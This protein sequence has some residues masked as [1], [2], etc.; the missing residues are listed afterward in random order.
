[1]AKRKGDFTTTER[2]SEFQETW[3]KNPV[4]GVRDLFGAEP[5][6]Q[7]VEL[8]R[9]A[10]DP[11][12]RVAVSSC[13]GAG[14][15]ATLAWLTYLFLLTQEDC[16]IMMTSP[17]FQQLNRVYKTEC[18]KWRGKMPKPIADLF[19][20]TREQVKLNSDTLVQR[21]D[22]VTLSTDNKESLQGGHAKNYV[23]LIDEASAA[24]PEAFAVLQKTLS[25]DTGGRFILTSNPTRS[26]GPF[27]DIFHKDEMKKLWKGLYFTAFENP[28]RA[29]NFIE[30][31]KSTYGEESDH[32]RVAVLGQFP[33]AAN[34]QFI[35]SEIVDLATTNDLTYP[36]HYN[37]P[38]VMGV[39]I[40]RFGDDETVLVIRQ[41]PK[42]LNIIRHNKLDTME[43]AEK[44][45]EAQSKWQAQVI[46]IDS[47]GVGAGTFDR[48]KQLK[49]PVREV[50]GSHKSSKPLEYFNMRAQL[51]GEMRLWLENGADIPPIE[52]LRNQLV[53]MTYGFTGKM[54]IQL[55]TKKDIKKTG[56]P[57]PDIADA[58][59]LTF[60]D[61]VYGV[62]TRKASARRIKKSKYAYV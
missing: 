61:T 62:K 23:A 38:I 59:S 52:A 28:R 60:A 21:A 35:S 46:F 17:S 54:Q 2:F 8:I 13:T 33:R 4:Q 15:T 50:M 12:A 3:L 48:C 26:V 55:T 7:Q 45:F 27:Y 36:A 10:W 14:K 40:A 29:P 43:V 6:P 53:G 1:M 58:L 16:R 34:S 32:Y 56:A 51:W 25:T 41:G 47:V 5:T 44:V 18:E 42:I 11:Q 37:Y 20:I 24:E 49:L 22:L 30:E 31:M 19:T 9:Y 57:S 39:D